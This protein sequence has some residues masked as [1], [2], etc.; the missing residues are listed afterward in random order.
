M[1]NTTTV[2]PITISSILSSIDTYATNPAAIQRGIMASLTAITNG[3]VSIV[4]ATNPFVF[5]LEQSSVNAAAGMQQAAA[6]TRRLYPAAAT[7]VNDLYLHM[8]DTDYVDIFALPTTANFTLM[9]NQQQLLNALVTDPITG[10]KQVVIPRNTV[11]YATTIPFSIQYPIIIRQLSHGGLQIVYDATD[12]S[13]L[14]VLSTNV[15]TYTILNDP[16]GVPYITFSVPTQQFD[17]V[18][19]INDVNSTGGFTTVVPFTNEYYYCRVYGSNPDGTWKEIQV[20]YTEMV[21]DPTIPTAVISV[22]NNKATVTIPIVYITTGLISGKVRIDVYETLGPM[23]QLL[24]NYVA[25]DFTA[26]F[27]YLDQNDA[28]VEVAAFT[29]ITGI[30][31]YSQDTTTGGRLALTF[32]QLQT[33]VINSAIG[34]RNIPITPSQIQTTLLDYGYTLVKNIDTITNRI[35]WATKALPAPTSPNL[36]TPANASVATVIT[37]VGAGASLQGCTT[38]ATGMTIT[39][40]ALVQ[41]INGISTLVTKSAYSA[42]MALPLPELCTTINLGSYTYSPFYYVLDTTTDT[43]AVRPYYLDTPSIINRSFIEENPITGL[44]VSIAASYSIV[45]LTNGYQLTLTTQSNSAYQDLPDNE[46]FCQLCFS[47]TAQATNAYMLGVQQP[48]LNNQGER[49][50]VFT[51]L[52]NYDI[53]LN[54]QLSQTSF[55]T[56]VP[57]YVPRSA[58]LQSVNVLF[59]TN[60]PGSSTVTP[61]AIDT[62]LGQFQLPS[63]TIGITNETLK[64]QFGY[65]LTTLWNSY[66][67]IVAPIPY[68]TYAANVPAT[69]ATDVYQVDPLTNASFSIVN[70]ALV[71]NVLHHAGDPVLNAAGAPTYLHLAGD[72]ILDPSTGLPTPI[73]NYS[74]LVNRSLDLVVIDGVYQFAND[75]ITLNYIAQIDNALVTSL[76]NDLVTINGEALEQTEVYYYPSISKG[77]VNVVADSGLVVNINAEQSFII[78]LYVTN[79]VYQDNKL[80]SS[81]QDTTIQTVGNYLAANATVARSQI[82]DA[83]SMVYGADV[84]GVRVSGL[85]GAANYNIV[86]VTDNSTTLSIN[87]ILAIQPNNQ[88]AVE[89]NI[90]IDFVVHD[91]N[92]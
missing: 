17:I 37:N 16:T 44:Q 12:V 2:T 47:G 87:K 25:N 89:E 15:I 67:S 88:I 1:T 63:G 11:F 6:L 79:E 5:C 52:T 3:T 78:T 55:A 54:D 48:R 90:E 43:F 64:L 59:S 61:T 19:L 4:D 69:Y 56:S 27:M 9:I 14:Q 38:H 81:L 33:R 82:E 18:E 74:T 73:A 13:P 32:E 71:Y 84:I 83:L 24:G 41:N 66:R 50:Y 10:I 53:D 58:L 75:A 62:F 72:P 39:S 28:S 70:G 49:T 46:V 29:S 40:A 35:Y 91:S 68:Q 80:I 22:A 76:T 23:T 60:A 26:D 7:T 34:P 45:K 8:S 30:A 21:Y 77:T 51:M 57:G 86:T 20:T 31:T 36:Y 85:G 65:S 42:L 92:M